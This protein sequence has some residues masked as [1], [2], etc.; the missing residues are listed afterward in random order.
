VLVERDDGDV[1]AVASAQRVRQRL[2]QSLAAPTELGR[3]PV[4]GQ[5]ELRA[6]FAHVRVHVVA[7]QLP[8]VRHGDEL[9][10][11]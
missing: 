3:L 11:E 2:D 6:R 5:R 7:F 10:L 4:A 8:A 9:A 1:N